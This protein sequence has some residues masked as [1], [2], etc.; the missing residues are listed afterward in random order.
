MEIKDG[1]QYTYNDNNIYYLS[2]GLLIF[3][4]SIYL[5]PVCPQMY[6]VV[7]DI[8]MDI[9]SI[10]MVI[11]KPV[12]GEKFDISQCEG[13]SALLGREDLP[14]LPKGMRYWPDGSMLLFLLGRAPD[15]RNF[16]E[17]NN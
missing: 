8:E 11:S 3:F 1:F 15:S 2:Y 4:L 6:H 9:R 7:N 10:R 17:S 13:L 16:T 12:T 14:I 5:F